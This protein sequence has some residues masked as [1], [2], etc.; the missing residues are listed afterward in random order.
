MSSY[1]LDR[2]LLLNSLGSGRVVT[3]ATAHSNWIDVNSNSALL[4]T[5]IYQR[6]VEAESKKQMADVI[7]FLN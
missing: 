2:E 5:N 3:T 7:H 6:N 4:G 1:V